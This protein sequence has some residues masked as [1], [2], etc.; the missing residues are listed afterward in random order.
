MLDDE[1]LNFTTLS[2][3]RSNPSSD[4]NWKDERAPWLP[5]LAIQITYLQ[6]RL[7]GPPE[8][9]AV[10]LQNNACMP[11]NERA[12]PIPH[13]RWRCGL[14]LKTSLPQHAQRTCSPPRSQGKRQISSRIIIHLLLPSF[15]LQRWLAQLPVLTYNLYLDR[16]HHQLFYLLGGASEVGRC[17][18][19]TRSGLEKFPQPVSL[20]SAL[21]RSVIHECN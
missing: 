11:A 1:Y 3:L 12:A 5:R 15:T 19:P 7:D 6:E 16:S 9:S 13:H 21:N 4:L 2:F 14:H 20:C 17:N 8:V 10:H 18:S